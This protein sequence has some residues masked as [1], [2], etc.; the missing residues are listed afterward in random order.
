MSYIHSL[1]RYV[2]SLGAIVLSTA[3]Y[4]QPTE[5]LFNDPPAPVRGWQPLVNLLDALS[6]QVDTAIPPNAKDVTD[7]INA[8]LDAGQNQEALELI[9]ARLK[10]RESQ[11]ELG[12]DVQLLFLQARAYSQ[13][14]KHNQ[15]I[16]LY[17]K[18]T[19]FYPELPEPWNNLA[20]EYMRQNKLALAQEALDMALLADPNYKIALEN[21]GELQLMLAQQS[22]EKARTTQNT[23]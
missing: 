17:K 7:R 20:T 21:Q 10:Q 13:L 15:A 19:I 14:A 8:L 3:L 23:P 6:P 16:E 9:Q 22:F 18:L 11:A 4:A 5:P 1:L 2:L 12:V